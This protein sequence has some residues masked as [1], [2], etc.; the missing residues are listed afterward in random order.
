[1]S[2]NKLVPPEYWNMHNKYYA[3]NE[4]GMDIAGECQRHI[5]EVMDAFHQY[6]PREIYLLFTE[7]AGAEAGSRLVKR[8][9]QLRQE[10]KKK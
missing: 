3:L 1:M 4:S 2:E 9:E 10:E 8:M 5:R 6:N 7:I